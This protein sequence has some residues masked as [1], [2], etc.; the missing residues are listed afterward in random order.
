MNIKWLIIN[1]LCAIA[2]AHTAA[3]ASTLHSTT[4]LAAADTVFTLKIDSINTVFIPDSVVRQM[5]HSLGM[6]DSCTNLATTP[7][8]LPKYLKRMQAIERRWMKLLPNQFTLQYAG[9][10]GLI[11][12]GVGWHYGR[13]NHWETDF[14]IG[15]VPKYHSSGAKASF[16]LKQRYIPWT[17]RISSRWAVQPLTTGIFFN[18]ISGDD[19]WRDLPDKYPRKYYV[20]PTKVRTNIY[21]GQRLRYKIPSNHRQLHSAVSLYYE[22]SSCDLYIVS[23]AVN[24]SFPWSQTLS[25][26][27][28]IRWEM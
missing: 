28:G 24:S 22:L 18:T 4:H 10:I 12:G 13:H 19:F 17:W 21:L 7:E 14:L 5:A 16:T 27:F 8:N 2:M 26:A 9:S 15:I 11:S 6:V 25:L 3:Q 20:F 23:K 1:L